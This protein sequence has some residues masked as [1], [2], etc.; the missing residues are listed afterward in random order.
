MKEENYVWHLTST[1]KLQLDT[2][3]GLKKVDL[4]QLGQHYKV[5]VNSSMGK[6][7]IK[8]LYLDWMVEEE[9]FP[10]V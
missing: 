7:D 5:F 1:A 3:N 2:F 6:A 4:L 10:E 9:L 8:K